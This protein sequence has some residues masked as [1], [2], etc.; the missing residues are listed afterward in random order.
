[1]NEYVLGPDGRERS[2]H[3][4]E[5]LPQALLKR[6]VR[7]SGG[8]TYVA[9][10][11]EVP[12]PGVLKRLIQFAK[13]DISLLHRKL[14]SVLTTRTV[15]NPVKTIILW[16]TQAAGE[17]AIDQAS[18]LSAFTSLGFDVE[19]TDYTRL[20]DE[21]LGPFTMLVIP[22]T[23]AKLL[24]Q[25]VI[26]RIVTGLNGGIT[27]ITDGESSLSKELGIRLG[28]AARVS[29][30]QDH[31]RQPGNALAGQTVGSLDSRARPGGGGR[32]LFGPRFAAA[33]G[34]QPPAE[35][36]TL[37]LFRAA[38]RLSHRTRVRPLPEFTADSSGRAARPAHG[39]ARGGGSLFRSRIPAKHLD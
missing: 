31:L 4:Q 18:F 16:N 8:E 30:L 19:K 14:E 12:A 13:G 25:P 9:L 35:T 3:S 10:R 28:P 23:T 5:I 1:M 21:D 22:W 33:A 38:F 20:L 11:Q 39:A 26:E 36:R 34:D 29:V 32:L 27:L 6:D 7:V 37:P 17:G 15:R 2:R 24:P